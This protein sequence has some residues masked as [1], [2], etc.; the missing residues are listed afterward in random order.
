M[1]GPRRRPA[2]GS[3]AP[4]SFGRFGSFSTLHARLR[5]LDRIRRHRRRTAV[6]GILDRARREA[7]DEGRRAV[8][9]VPPALVD[10]AAA[11]AWHP[12][13]DL[14]CGSDEAERAAT[15]SRASRPG[16]GP[17]PRY[18]PRRRIDHPPAAVR[19]CRP[20]RR[21]PR[22]AVGGGGAAIERRRRGRKRRRSPAS[23]R[24]CALDHPGAAAARP[25][26]PRR[27]VR[28][29]RLGHAARPVGRAARGTGGRLEPVHRRR[30]AGDDGLAMD[31][32]ADRPRPVRPRRP[33]RRTGGGSISSC[34]T[35]WRGALTAYL[36]AVQR[37]A[38]TAV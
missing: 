3:P 2:A 13:I 15:V 25:V 31:Q 23:R 28:R 10:L 30:G 21:H 8:I 27:P 32:G 36:R 38:P 7:E 12:K 19:G 9:S 17:A 29:S 4:R 18:R 37:I 24:L 33:T 5:G 11:R 14:L 6:A 34:R 35:R 26:L 1:A 20:D 22:L 16:D